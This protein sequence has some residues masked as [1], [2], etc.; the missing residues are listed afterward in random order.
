MS[1]VIL[2]LLVMFLFLVFHYQTRQTNKE[3]TKTNESLSI[4][5]H[6]VHE[7]RSWVQCHEKYENHDLVFKSVNHD[8]DY[9]CVEIKFRCRFC[10][11]TINKAVSELTKQERKALNDFL[12]IRK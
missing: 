6:A 10:G 2:L 7:L 5:K 11:K 8:S 9:N 3:I 12:N 1:E 4:F